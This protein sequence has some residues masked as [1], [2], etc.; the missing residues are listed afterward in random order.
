MEAPPVSSQKPPAAFLGDR[1][2]E[3]ILLLFK[4]NPR[5]GHLWKAEGPLFVVNSTC[6]YFLNTELPC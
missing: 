1:Y 2:I 6:D 3:Q 4:L 5:D